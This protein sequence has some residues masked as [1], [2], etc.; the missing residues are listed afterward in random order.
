MIWVPFEDS[1][2]PNELSI[3]DFEKKITWTPI[4]EEPIIEDDG[5]GKKSQT[6]SMEKKDENRKS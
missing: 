2:E 4:E 6:Q 1:E 3:D 5:G